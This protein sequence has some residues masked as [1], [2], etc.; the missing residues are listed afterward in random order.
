MTLPFMEIFKEWASDYDNA[1]FGQN[2]EYYDVFVN[3]DFMLREAA[4]NAE[5]K[6]LEFGPGTGNLTNL[7]L[8]KGLNV[9]PV[10]PSDEMR[11]I[12]ENKTGVE[13]VKG[14]FLNF[15]VDQV[16]TIITSY[17]FHHLTDEEKLIAL[18]KY[19]SILTENGKIIILDTIFN[20][21]EEKQQ[22]INHYELLGYKSLVEDLNREYYPLKETMEDIAR[23][24]GYDYTS[25]QMNR[26]AHLQVLTHKKFL[27]PLD[28]VGNTP[29]VELTKFELNEGVRLFAKLESYNIGGSVKDRLAFNLIQ[30]A[31][32]HGEIRDEVV[33][34]TAGN[35]GIGLALACLQHDLQLTV[36]VPEKFSIEKQQLMKA[37]G[38][39]IIHTPTDKGMTYAREQAEQYSKD[40]NAYY[41]NQ[42]ENFSNPL[43]Y[44]QLAQ[45]IQAAV[46]KVDMIVAGAGSGG[47]FEG[48]ARH[49]KEAHKVIVEPEGSILSCGEVSNHRIEGIGIEQWPVFLS[50]SNIDV[51]ESISDEDGF[52]MVTELA[53]REGLL[54]GSS[55]AAALCA[56]LKQ[57]Q[58][59]TDKNI[60]VIFPDA[61]ERYI[62]SNI[63]NIN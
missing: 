17:A 49:F 27:K 46:E 7:L 37:L 24:S 53:K 50:K 59:V 38:A 26:F 4:K 34:A 54:V 6:V 60:V 52:Q 10:E 3:Y 36:F 55:S 21:K 20:S 23:I 45:E 47:T 39:N 5:G 61:A 42:F 18:K 30:S 51:V 11:A 63:F 28:L 13:F 9:I 29:L 16:D 44:D 12:G 40:N 8:A 48:L 32:D 2:P 31:I 56:A 41:T 43:S 15:S 25:Q 14:D 33:E 19:K 22:M 57:A 62:S 1:V 35:T 58:H